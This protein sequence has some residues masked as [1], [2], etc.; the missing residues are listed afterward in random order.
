MITDLLGKH[1]QTAERAEGLERTPFA[2]RL[3]RFWR[4]EVFEHH[5]LML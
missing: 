4:M 2:W 5:I 1:V 3:H